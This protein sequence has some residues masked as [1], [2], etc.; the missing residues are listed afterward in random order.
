MFNKGD[1]VRKLPVPPKHSAWHLQHVLEEFG[2][3]VEVQT[4]MVETCQSQLCHMTIACKDTKH[5]NR[6]TRYWPIDCLELVRE[7][8]PRVGPNTEPLS[9]FGR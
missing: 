6:S 1:I 4:G 9:Q 8:P 2:D 7:A 5:A 3:V